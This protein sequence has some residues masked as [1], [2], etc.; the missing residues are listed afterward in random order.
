MGRADTASSTAR[1]PVASEPLVRFVLALRSRRA[2]STKAAVRGQRYRSPRS[3]GCQALRDQCFRCLRTSAVIRS[4][5][6]LPNWSLKRDLHRH[7]TWPARRSGLSSASR[8]KRH[9]GYGPLAQTLGS[10]GWLWCHALAE[11]GHGRKDTA[12]DLLSL[13]SR[14]GCAGSTPF[15]R[16]GGA[17]SVE[18]GGGCPR[19]PSVRDTLCHARVRTLPSS[20]I[21]FWV[22]CRA[23]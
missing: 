7:G 21:G 20:A 19:R 8:A 12:S 17:A 23:A 9:S 11:R 2:S 10:T 15:W 16:Y 18:P 22:P 13:P 3:A 6:V 5:A 14:S 1:C 4:R